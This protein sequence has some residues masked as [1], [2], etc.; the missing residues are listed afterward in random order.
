[1]DTIDLVGKPFQLLTLAFRGRHFVTA[2]LVP[3]TTLINDKGAMSGNASIPVVAIGALIGGIVAGVTEIFVR[4]Y[5]HQHQRPILQDRE[6]IPVRIEALDD[7]ELEAPKDPSPSQPPVPVVEADNVTP[8]I[9]K[10]APPVEEGRKKVKA[11]AVMNIAFN[12]FKDAVTKIG[13]PF[14]TAWSENVMPAITTLL[15]TAE[16]AKHLKAEDVQPSDVYKVYEVSDTIKNELTAIMTGYD[17]LQDRD[18]AILE[19]MDRYA[20][21]IG[22]EMDLLTKYTVEKI[23]SHID[24]SM[25]A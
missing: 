25:M 18:V 24:K 7:E 4:R 9:V 1:M 17:A 16:G 20:K 13:P 11:G 14:L 8:E 10:E 19:D 2:T 3:V 5:Q 6:P 15:A 23:Q 21:Q 12:G 22:H